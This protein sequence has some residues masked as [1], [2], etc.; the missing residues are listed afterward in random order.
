MDAAA[1][2]S[3]LPRPPMLQVSKIEPLRLRGVL[4]W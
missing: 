4:T 2:F 3:P 1:L